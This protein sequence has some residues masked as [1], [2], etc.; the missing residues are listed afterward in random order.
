[1]TSTTTKLHMY[2]TQ[3]KL[4]A[5]HN[6]MEEEESWKRLE[7]GMYT[8]SYQTSD[9]C[10]SKMSRCLLVFEMPFLNCRCWKK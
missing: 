2:G 7:P 6:I 5:K 10:P 1:M 8:K 3:M 4:A 9:P